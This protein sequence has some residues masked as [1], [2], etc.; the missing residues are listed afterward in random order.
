MI[1]TPASTGRNSTFSSY[2]P[3]EINISMVSGMVPERVAQI[4]Q[5]AVNIDPRI[6]AEQLEHEYERITLRNSTL[7]NAHVQLFLQ[8]HDCDMKDVSPRLW[9]VRIGLAW[10]C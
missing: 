10:S 7:L 1:A 5:H 8:G 4:I 3:S 9:Y 2:R 6:R